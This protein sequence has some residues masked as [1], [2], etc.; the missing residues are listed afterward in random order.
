V[1]KDD[2]RWTSELGMGTD[3]VNEV[4]LTSLEMVQFLLKLEEEYGIQEGLDGLDFSHMTSME[5][6]HGFLRAEA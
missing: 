2:S 4:G 5:R 3:L 1:I 6:L